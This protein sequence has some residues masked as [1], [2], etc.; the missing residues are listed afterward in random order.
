MT[1]FLALLLDALFGEPKWLWSRLPHPA[2]LMGNLIGRA[3][4][5]IN[6]APHQKPKGVILCIG[7]TGLAG[8]IGLLL[9]QLGP[10][11]E[12]LV[13]AILVAQKSLMQHVQDVAQS[14]RLSLAA[15]RRSVSMIVGRDTAEMD[16]PQVARGAIESA[17]ENFSDGIVAPVFWFALAGLPGVILYKMINTA[18]SMIGYKNETY[19]DFG[20]ACAR[21]DDLLNWAPARLSAFG[22]WLMTGC[23]TSWDTIIDEAKLHRSPNAGWPEAAMAYALNISLSGPRSY[24]GNFEKFPWVNAAGH[25]NIGP[26]EIEKSV[27]TLWRT[28]AAMA[29]LVAGMSLALLH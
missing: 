27:Q 12:I 19:Q 26:V 20:W 11:A 9:A 5:V 29:L 2:V 23:R 4:G 21:L 22:I 17:A 28:W 8:L 1:L 14:L 7:L 15:G 16:A 6:H 13:T 3:T 25:K 10:A 18:D 24:E